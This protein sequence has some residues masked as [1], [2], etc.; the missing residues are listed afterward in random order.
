MKTFLKILII[1][2]ITI[3]LIV[4]LFKTLQNNKVSGLIAGCIF[5]VISLF[6]LKRLIYNTVYLKTFSFYGILF[7]LLFAVVPL[8]AVRLF[9]LNEDFSNLIVFGIKADSFHKISESIYMIMVLCTALDLLRVLVLK[10]PL[11]HKIN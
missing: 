4:V 7:H 9:Y 5:F 6:F 11:S 10:I 8:M 1:Q 2:V 3:P